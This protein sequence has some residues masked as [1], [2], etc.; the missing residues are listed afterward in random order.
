MPDIYYST[1]A[2]MNGPWLL[3]SQALRDLDDRIESEWTRLENLQEEL[4]DKQA[5]ERF[6]DWVKSGIIKRAK[7]EL[8]RIREEVSE[9]SLYLN[10]SEKV[11]EIGFTD[12]STYKN[13]GLGPAQREN[14]L[15]Q[16]LPN[17]FRYSVTRAGIN[18]RVNC[19]GNSLRIDVSPNENPAARELFVSI[20]QW[21]ERYKPP[22]W[23]RAW[24]WLGGIQWMIWVLIW[25]LGLLFISVPGK[26]ETVREAKDLINIGITD[27]NLARAVSVLL[28]LQSNYYP[29]ATTQTPSWFWVIFLGGFVICVLTSFFPK[30]IL[31]I[32][33]GDTRIRNWKFWMNLIGVSI[34][35]FLFVSLI[36]PQFLQFI[37][38]LF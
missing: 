37:I 35:S 12:G 9:D 4:L 19:S 20:R 29:N 23:Q 33:K 30:T 22:I 1:Q 10:R 2:T 6:E 13:D 36:W 17:S 7:K 31:G 16:K 8:E 24:G 27:T 25:L 5:Q 14:A 18:C 15:L 34:P 11:V 26:S 32:G 28:Q 21:A 3:D 38:A